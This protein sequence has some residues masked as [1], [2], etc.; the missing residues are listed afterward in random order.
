MA[1]ETEKRKI[2]QNAEKEF[3]ISFFLL[4]IDQQGNPAE[5]LINSF[6][7]DDLHVASY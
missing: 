4:P 7:S 3:Y 5:E 1:F 2:A 6:S